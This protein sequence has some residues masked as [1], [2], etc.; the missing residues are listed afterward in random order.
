M[1]AARR[2]NS[3]ERAAEIQKSS[4]EL[5]DKMAADLEKGIG[6]GQSAGEMIDESKRMERVI[7]NMRSGKKDMSKSM[8]KLD[9]IM[10]QG[11]PARNIA[12]RSSAGGGGLSLETARAQAGA[13]R[14]REF[15]QL[16]TNNQ[17]NDLHARLCANNIARES[18]MEREVDM[19]NKHNISIRQLLTVDDRTA[20][21]LVNEERF[22]SKKNKLTEEDHPEFTSGLKKRDI[23]SWRALGNDSVRPTAFGGGRK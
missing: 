13:R 2:K 17:A 11:M 8:T 15:Q 3:K 18:E 9:T 4:K 10:S 6:G 14:I 12:R 16:G 5:A 7:N 22:E 19:D 21:L 23:V 1:S 20:G